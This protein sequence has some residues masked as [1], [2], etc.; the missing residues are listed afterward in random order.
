MNYSNTPSP[1]IEQ[2]IANGQISTSDIYVCHE[3]T[4]GGYTRVITKAPRQRTTARLNKHGKTI[5]HSTWYMYILTPEGM[6][7]SGA[8]QCSNSIKGYSPLD[9]PRANR[10]GFIYSER[11]AR[12]LINEFG[13]FYNYRGYR[14]GVEL[15]GTPGIAA[16]N[17]DVIF[18]ANFQVATRKA[19]RNLAVIA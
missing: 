9:A 13:P 14:P 1:I 12:N 17:T 6:N 18:E 19:S 3:T 15:V 4:L 8:G 10:F 11:M 2:S 5:D 16:P 7:V